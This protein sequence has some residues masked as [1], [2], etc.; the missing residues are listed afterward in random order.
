MINSNQSSIDSLGLRSLSDLNKVGKDAK[1]DQEDFLELMTTQLQ[2]QDPFKPMENGDFLAQMAQFSTVDGIQ[3]LQKS[4]EQLSQSLVS[5]Q[6]L[7][8]AGLVGR[9][10]LAPTGL[11]ALEP[12][13]AVKGVVQLPASSGEV[14]VQ[15]TDFSGQTI[16]SLSLGSQAAGNAQFQWD[17]LMDNG[18]YAPAGTYFVTAQ[19]MQDGG[20]AAVETLISSTVDSVTLGDANGLLLDLRGVG[21]LDFAQV[22][23]I[24]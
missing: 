1:L 15:V 7:Q 9:S 13:G 21:Q 19:A 17:G 22:R 10:V 5:N 3:N 11:A 12:G 23:Q 14:T 16:R 2:N 18:Q 24:L 4:F 20:Q 6:A 8:A